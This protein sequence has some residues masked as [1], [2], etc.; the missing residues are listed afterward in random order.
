MEKMARNGYFATVGYEFRCVC[1]RS[2]MINRFRT[3]Y[4]AECEDGVAGYVDGA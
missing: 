3:A 4:V 2:C 1:I